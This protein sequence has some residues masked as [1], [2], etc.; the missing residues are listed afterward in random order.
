MARKHP[1]DMTDEELRREYP[2]GVP[3]RVVEAIFVEKLLRGEDPGR[4]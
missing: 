4:W 2:E 1:A 3:R